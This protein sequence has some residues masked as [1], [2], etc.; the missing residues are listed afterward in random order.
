MRLAT[1]NVNSA[2]T[3]VERITAFLERWDVDVLAMQETKCRV[4]QFPR[5]PFEDMGYHVEVNGANQ[6]NGVAIVS[7]MDSTLIGTSF[8]GQPPFGEPAALEPRTIGVRCG[9]IAVWSLY[10][11]NGRELG[12]PHFDYKLAYLDALRTHVEDTLRKDP[13]SLGI[14]VGDF[15]IAW[16]D[17]D[18]W[19]MAAFEGAT[20][21]TADERAR[22]DALEAAGLKEVTRELVE[23]YTYWDYQRLRFPKNEGMRIDYAFATPALGAHVVAA[24]LDREERKGKG[25]SDH[26]PV[27]VDIA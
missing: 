11:P 13:D 26:I 8:P 15:N 4:D 7:R 21:V 17:S 2:R 20:H 10:I 1:W 5:K 27:I 6:W 16:R 9:G 22:L 24:H 19:D 18:V 3:R 12:H 25:A 14:Y 23:G